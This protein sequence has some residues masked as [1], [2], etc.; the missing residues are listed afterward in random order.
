MVGQIWLFKLLVESGTIGNRNTT[1]AT[2]LPKLPPHDLKKKK[3]EGESESGSESESESEYLG[4]NEQSTL[5]FSLS[6]IL[7]QQHFVVERNGNGNG[8]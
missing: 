6:S 8:K 4:R 3:I 5:S 1:P 7:A 2:R